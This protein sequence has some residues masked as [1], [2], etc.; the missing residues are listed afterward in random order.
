MSK[1]ECVLFLRQRELK[2][3]VDPRSPRVGTLIAT[4]LEEEE[5][6]A[7]MPSF[8]RSLRRREGED[9]V[10][11]RDGIPRSGVGVV[12]SPR[13]VARGLA[14]STREPASIRSEDERC[15]HTLGL[16]ELLWLDG[17][18]IRLL[19]EGY[20]DISSQ[21]LQDEG[22]LSLVSDE[23]DIRRLRLTLIGGDIGQRIVAEH[24]IVAERTIRLYQAEAL[25]V[26]VTQLQ[27]EVSLALEDVC[28][29]DCEEE[30]LTLDLEGRPFRQA[31]D[32]DLTGTDVPDECELDGAPF[33]LDG[34]GRLQIGDVAV[35]TELGD[36]YLLSLVASCED[37]EARASRGLSEGCYSEGNLRTLSSAKGDP[38][39][40]R[41]RGEA[42]FGER[43]RPRTTCSREVVLRGEDT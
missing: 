2:D 12:S 39:G 23:L 20:W 35:G 29:L 9:R 36:G 24:R 25:T 34:V 7:V 42:P 19:F 11:N 22:L 13:Q 21:P 3:R 27:R 38:A 4:T 30:L 28:A 5:V 32:L 8:L 43:D 6:Q 16:R 18:R 10:L 37:D 15:R 14:I 17:Q 26:E 1:N 33:T 41:L 40:L 31:L